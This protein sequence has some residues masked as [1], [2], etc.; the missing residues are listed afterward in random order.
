[1]VQLQISSLASSWYYFLEWGMLKKICQIVFLSI[2]LLTTQQAFAQATQ[3]VPPQITTDEAL[4]KI[5]DLK[6]LDYPELQVV[7]RASE[8]LV[9]E[10]ASVREHGMMLMFPYL[11]SAAMTLSSG[12][13]VGSNLRTDFSEK[14]KHDATLNSSLAAGVG[15]AGIGLVYWFTNSDN[16][17]SALVQIRN[18]KNKDRRTE[19]LRERLAEEAFE[20]SARTISQWK[21]AFAATNF[22]ASAQLTGK[23]KGDTNIIPSLSVLASL[24][25]LFVT[26][27]YETNH[28]KLQ[29]YKR[30]IYV[31]LT[32]FDYQYSAEQ[33]SM[34]PR[35]NAVWTF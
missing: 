34:Q 17:G 6:A 18:L 19:L 4:P 29:D 7:P 9:L 30:R 23:S 14:D 13:A 28:S 33:A 5:E 32:W 2:L 35:L 27:S 11:A 1:M 21:W 24:L 25:P 10:S 20:K 31:P 3:A 22:I 26:S 12:L 15:L 8:R 16:Y